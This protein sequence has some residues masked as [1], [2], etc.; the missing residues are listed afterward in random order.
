VGAGSLLA[1][2]YVLP[3]STSLSFDSGISPSEGV[4]NSF[5]GSGLDEDEEES[6]VRSAFC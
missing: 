4:D 1:R 2:T 5:S 3:P 6:H